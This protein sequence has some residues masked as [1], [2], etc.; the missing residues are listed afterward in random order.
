[1]ALCLAFAAAACGGPEPA[2]RATATAVADAVRAYYAA[3][4][5]GDGAAM[6]ALLSDGE[7]DRLATDEV[8][9]RTAAERTADAL[10][11]ELRAEFTGVTV[12]G[13]EVDGD[14][15]AARVRIDSRFASRPRTNT[16]T[17]TRDGDR[18][19]LADVPSD[20]RPDPVTTCVVAGIEAFE[21]GDTDALWRRE[22][23]ADFVFFLR[24]TCSR[25]V[26]EGVI[27]AGEGALGARGQERLQRISTTVLHE[28]VRAGRVDPS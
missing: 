15:A 12:R 24:E 5:R 26:H 10:P 11:R 6:C 18:W 3:L 21:H 19:R 20:A 13:V 23:R 2:D 17:L 28:M 22:G 27:K 1:L 4:A 14:T 7:R 25:G 9:C 8:P 16:I